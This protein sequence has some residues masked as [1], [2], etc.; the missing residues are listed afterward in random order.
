MR[1]STI[2]SGVLSC[3]FLLASTMLVGPGC[4]NSTS[5]TGSV[6][7]TISPEQEQKNQDA[8]RDFYKKSDSAK[9]SPKVKN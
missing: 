8:M 5:K 6:E 1:E 3:A 2:R 4:D 7:K 9:H